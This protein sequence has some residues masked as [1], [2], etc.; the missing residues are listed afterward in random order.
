MRKAAARRY[1]ISLSARSVTR[2]LIASYFVGLGLGLIPGVRVG[3]LLRPVLP[4]PAAD[5]LAGFLIVGLALL[6]L[7][8]RNRRT[9]ALLLALVVFSASYRTMMIQSGPEQM[10]VFWRDIALIGG[11]LLTYR[12][13]SGGVRIAPG[14]VLAGALERLRPTPSASETIVS[15]MPG[16]HKGTH[17]APAGH[18]KR[19]RSELY[20]QDL[21]VVRAL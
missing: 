19:V 10:A 12:D 11:L 3:I 20:R 13:E 6:V 16:E 5:I 8:R 1:E 18:P 7:F 15:A 2:L 21:K 9:P 4:D 14:A 17:A